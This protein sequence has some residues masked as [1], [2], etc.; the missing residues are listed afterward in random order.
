MKQTKEGQQEK[1]LV[2]FLSYFSAETEL[3]HDIVLLLAPPCLHP[4]LPYIT[5]RISEFFVKVTTSR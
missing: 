1:S 5:D 3:Y 2:E 4:G